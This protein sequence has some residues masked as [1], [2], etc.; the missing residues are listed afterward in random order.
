[1]TVTAKLHRSGKRRK[2]HPGEML[3]VFTPGMWNQ[4][5]GQLKKNAFLHVARKG[6][7]TG[8]VIVACGRDLGGEVYSLPFNQWL[9]QT[10]PRV[11][12]SCKKVVEESLAGPEDAKP[13]LVETIPE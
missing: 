5:T 4:R 8:N 11:C 1:M 3:I 10:A 6:V 7:S 13:E 12:L 2:L 9:Y